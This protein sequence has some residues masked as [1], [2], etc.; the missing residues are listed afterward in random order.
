MRLAIVMGTRPE[1]IK[2]APVARL[3]ATDPGLDAEVWLT[4]QHRGM[5]DQVIDAFELAP[6]LDLELMRPDQQLTD[7]MAAAIGGVGEVIRA[8]EP[9]V[10]LVQGDTTTAS[11]SA[12]AA[13]SEHV[14]VGHVEAGLRSGDLEAPFPEEFNRRLVSIAAHWHFAPTERAAQALRRE[15]MPSESIHVTGNTVVDALLHVA[16]QAP[17][18]GFAERFSGLDRFVLVTAH[19]RENHGEPLQAICDGLETLAA[20][21]PDVRFVVPVH[22]NPRVVDVIGE[23]LGGTPS[24]ILTEP[25]DYPTMIHL[26]KRATLVV[27]DSGGLQ[28]EAPAFGVPVLVM[29]R[30]TERPEGVEAGV[31]R[32]VGTDAEAIHREVTRLLDDPEAYA[33][34]ARAVSPFGDGTAAQQIIDVLH[35]S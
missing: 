6:T 25:L 8:R 23:R 1:A 17:P 33:Q 4:G 18:P 7:L 12:I 10:V 21:Q 13:F 29:R 15:G 5:L 3:A 11:A 28:E 9:D 24:I 34:M 22:P 35:R 31:A 26:M 19:R 16:G 2:L 30:N 32:L 14:P 27:T 20:D